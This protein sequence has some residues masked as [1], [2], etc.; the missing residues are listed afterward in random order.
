MEEDQVVHDAIQVVGDG[1]ALH[2]MM[3]LHDILRYIE[4]M[5]VPFKRYIEA[6]EAGM[7]QAPPMV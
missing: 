7:A 5:L 1:G 4:Q 2:T 3:G 6:S